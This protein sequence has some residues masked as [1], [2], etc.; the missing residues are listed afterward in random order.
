MNHTSGS[1]PIDLVALEG[2]S[3]CGMRLEPNMQLIK[4]ILFPV[5]LSDASPKIAPCVKEVAVKLKVELHLLYVVPILCNST[6]TYLLHSYIRNFESEI[7][8]EAVKQLQHFMEVFFDDE[9]C[10]ARIVFGDPAEEIVNYAESEE[11]DLIVMPTHGERDTGGDSVG[12]VAERVKKESPV[13]VLIVDSHD[14]DYKVRL[15][16]ANIGRQR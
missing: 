15:I 12:S 4:K 13:P 16:T 9:P 14:H 7:A 1:I 11:I 6:S 8:D 10:E 2:I 5:D 3:Q